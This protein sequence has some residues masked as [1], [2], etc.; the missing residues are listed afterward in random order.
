MKQKQQQKDLIC[1][2]PEAL[3]VIIPN[4]FTFV[5]GRCIFEVENLFCFY[6]AFFFVICKKGYC[7]TNMLF[8]F[9]N[10]YCQDFF[11]VY[12]LLRF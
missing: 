3:T 4:G 11:S 10:S 2:Q 12:F 6:V 9:N 7:Y 8:F 1:L 5:V